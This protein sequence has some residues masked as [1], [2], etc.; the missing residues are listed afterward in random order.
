MAALEIDPR[1]PFVRGECRKWVG[2]RSLSR[3]RTDQKQTWIW[4]PKIGELQINDRGPYG[5]AVPAGGGNC[6]R[7][8]ASARLSSAESSFRIGGIAGFELPR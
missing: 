6:A 5:A 4:S 1:W 8:A 2:G 7:Y 3:T